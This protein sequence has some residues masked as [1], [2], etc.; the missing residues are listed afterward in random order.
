MRNMSD[1]QHETETH[2][3]TELTSAP[4][5]RQHRAAIARHQRKCSVCQHPERESIEKE[6]LDW[7]SPQKIARDYGIAAFAR[8]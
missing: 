4:P 5:K 1:E 7:R 3:E 6:Y 8:D 2:T